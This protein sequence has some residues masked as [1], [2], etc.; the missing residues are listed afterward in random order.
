MQVVD[1]W[2]PKE[3]ASASHL[4]RR[5][6]S[7]RNAACARRRSDGEL[8][9]AAAG[10]RAGRSGGILVTAGPP[11]AQPADGLAIDFVVLP[12]RARLGEIVQ[13]VRDGRLRTNI[14]N[15]ASLV[16]AVAALNPTARR[17]GKTIIQMCP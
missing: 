14:D 7:G 17:K 15:V 3:H 2:R 5:A 4:A 8:G 10:R 6:A 11:E 16:D 13:R 9:C 12:D 1:L